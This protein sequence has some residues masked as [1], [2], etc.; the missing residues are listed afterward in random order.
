LVRSF[1]DK[2]GLDQSLYLEM[3]LRPVKALD[4]IITPESNDCLFLDCHSV[5]QAA[6]TSCTVHIIMASCWQ[7]TP[8]HRHKRLM[9]FLPG[10]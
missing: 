5:V 8:M 2:L 6:S 3:F 10:I 7:L 1:V 9:A 4:D